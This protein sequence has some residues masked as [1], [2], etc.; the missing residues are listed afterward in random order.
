MH[1]LS[2]ANSIL[3]AVRTEMARRPGVRAAKVGVRVG[4]LSGVEPEALSFSFD[5]LVAG[6]DLAPLVL[7]IETRP[8]LQRCR[9]C[10]RTFQVHDFDVT[11]PDCGTAQTHCVGGNELEMVY[12]EL[13][14]L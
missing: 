12:L 5:A 8:R 10:D 7:D 11:C 4:E 1:E 2:I 3:E 14:E 6:S 13:A 9:A